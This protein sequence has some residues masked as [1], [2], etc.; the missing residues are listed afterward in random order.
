MEDQAC[1]SSSNPNCLHGH[2]NTRPRPRIQD[3]FKVA[4]S[5]GQA[6]WRSPP[7]RVLHHSWKQ[8]KQDSGDVIHR[9]VSWRERQLDGGYAQ[10]FSRTRTN[11]GGLYRNELDR[12]RYLQL[13]I[14]DKHSSS[15]WSFASSKVTYGRSLLQS[16]IRFC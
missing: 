15:S 7:T 9:S 11:S 14:P 6:C 16:Q 13:W 1:S 8:W 3:S 4:T 5:C 10:G 2:Q 12:I